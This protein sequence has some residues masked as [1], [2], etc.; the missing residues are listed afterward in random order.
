M[1]TFLA[2]IILICQ[3]FWLI[4]VEEVLVTVG[5]IVV[6]VVAIGGNRGHGDTTGSNIMWVVAVPMLVIVPSAQEYTKIRVTW[7]PLHLKN[8]LDRKN[9]PLDLPLWTLGIIDRLQSCMQL[10]RVIRGRYCSTESPPL[11]CE[12]YYP[13]ADRPHTPVGDDI[14]AG[15]SG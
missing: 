1:T 13:L 4:S 9:Q 2:G 12:W 7:K 8:P 14:N 5:V 10:G 3:M 11:P 15:N 6:V